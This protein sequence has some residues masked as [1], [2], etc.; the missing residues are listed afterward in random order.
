MGSMGNHGLS[1]NS[2]LFP[3]LPIPGKPA[4]DH[5]IHNYVQASQ[6]IC[7]GFKWPSFERTDEIAFKHICN[8]TPNLL[9]TMMQQVFIIWIF[10]RVFYKN[11]FSSGKTAAKSLF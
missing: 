10:F 1:M 9:T 8:T 11:L 6:V 4:S 2:M 5:N 7:I 3:M